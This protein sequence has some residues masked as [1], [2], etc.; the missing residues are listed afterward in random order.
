MTKTL[1][2]TDLDGTFLGADAKVSAY[3]ARSY[4]S[5]VQAGADITFV[6]AR[7]PATI[8]P[9]MHALAPRIPAVCMTGAAWWDFSSR[10]YTRMVYH[11]AADVDTILRICA[12]N[13]VVPFVYTLDRGS[14][15]LQGYHSTPALTAEEQKFV[16]ERTISD[17]KT[18]HIGTP[19]PENT[20]TS[21][22]LLFAMG[23]PDR[24]K[25][26]A[27]AIREH[28]RCYASWYPDTYNPGLALLEVFA[29]GVSK[30][31]GLLA[32][33][34][35]IG[36]KRIVAFGDNLNDIP[37]LQVADVAVAVEN[38]HPQVK[39]IADVVIGPNPADS[40]IRYITRY[41]TSIC[42]A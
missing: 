20:R 17:L 29:E 1:F 32:L 28:T 7:T 38:A 19:A 2:A 33:K 25:A 21:T 6:T 22:V 30:A 5:L 8:E 40:V 27:M 3:T 42:D 10:S 39:E 4:N 35:A 26:T 15:R 24:I 36:A 31:A 34:E 41:H 18:F 16:F 11:R 23:E 13:G 9:L 12:A 14:N 37:M